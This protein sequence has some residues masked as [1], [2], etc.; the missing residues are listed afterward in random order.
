M[1]KP[2]LQNRQGFLHSSRSIFAGFV[3]KGVDVEKRTVRGMASVNVPDSHGTLILPEAFDL[4]DY[5]KNPVGMMFHDYKKLPVAKAN[6]LNVLGNGLEIGFEIR[7][8]EDG[9]TCL[10]ACADGTLCGF[11]VGGFMTR[12]ICAWDKKELIETLPQYAQDYL[13]SGEIW[14]VITKFKLREVSFTGV[15]SNP[16]TLIYRDL[17]G[18]DLQGDSE[19][20]NMVQLASRLDELFAAVQR[21]EKAVEVPGQV[22]IGYGVLAD[23]DGNGELQEEDAA[24]KSICVKVE[25]EVCEDGEEVEPA[26]PETEPQ[27]EPTMETVIVPEQKS[28]DLQEETTMQTISQPEEKLTERE[29]EL[30]KAFAALLYKD[31]GR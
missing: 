10:D 25:V 9:N 14:C 20:R 28:K 24:E 16:D 12:Y 18:V 31:G 1:L 3:P 26:E 27:D 29:L 11:S 23:G 30:I 21:I 5:V 15:P 7:K 2:S 17:R 19:L 8:S 6:E 4:D 13:A 22:G